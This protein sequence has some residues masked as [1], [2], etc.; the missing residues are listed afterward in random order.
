MRKRLSAIKLNLIQL[1]QSYAPL[2]A[3][4]IES[5]TENI[6]LK[7]IQTKLAQVI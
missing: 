1:D 5:E 3:E 4:R 7:C 2:V 6:T